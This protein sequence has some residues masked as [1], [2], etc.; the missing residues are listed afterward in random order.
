[1]SKENNQDPRDREIEELRREVL[2]LRRTAEMTAGRLLLA[3]TQAIAIRHELEQKRRGFGLM[4]DLAVSLGRETDYE[5]VFV[6]VSRRINAALNMQRTAVLAP[7]PDGGFSA[8]VL[9][10]Y[11][12][13]E[14]KEILARRID[15]APEMLDPSSPVLITGADDEERLRSVREALA[16]PYL[17]SSPVMLYDNVVALLV[18]GRLVEE[19]PYLPRLGKSDVETVQTVSVYLAAMFTGFR[20][21]QTEI[22]A[23]Y[24]PLTQ[25]FNHRSTTESLRQTLEHA[26]RNGYHAAALFVDLDGFKEVNDT[27]GHAAGDLVLRIVSER[28]V[29]CVRDSDIVG[30]IGGDEFAVILS[31]ISQPEDAAGIAAKIIEKLSEP[32]EVQGE[33]CQVGAS[34]GIAIYPEHGRDESTLLQAADDA[35]YT[36]K[37]SGKNAYRY[38]GKV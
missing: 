12:A 31:H 20:L 4:A 26:G 36:V 21:R 10:G 17:V 18:T 38:A 5:S 25:L 23:N 7:D 19:R 13:E 24:D 16:L 8:A 14:Q 30:R 34:I 33:R 37:N 28:L 32:M 9:Q 11:P 6:S 29:N 2:Y 35:M 1:M 3:D 15:I 22:L 27:Y